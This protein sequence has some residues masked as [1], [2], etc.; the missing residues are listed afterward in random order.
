[1]NK[2]LF[3]QVRDIEL[4]SSFQ[5]NNLILFLSLI[6]AFATLKTVAEFIKIAICQATTFEQGVSAYSGNYKM[7]IHPKCICDMIKTHSQFLPFFLYDQT[8]A[9]FNSVKIPSYSPIS[10]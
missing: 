7:Q 9:V 6:L 5:Q 4:Y 1:M 2:C 3:Y 8:I 10:A